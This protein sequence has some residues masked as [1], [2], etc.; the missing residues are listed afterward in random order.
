M[1]QSLCI[2]YVWLHFS[3][4]Q[5]SIAE[6]SLSPLSL[7]FEVENSS[8]RL[9]FFLALLPTIAIVSSIEFQASFEGPWNALLLC[10][11]R[12]IREILFALNSSSR[13]RTLFFVCGAAALVRCRASFNV[14]LFDM[15]IPSSLTLSFFFPHR[16][17][18]WPLKGNSH[19][20][21]FYSV[22]LDSHNEVSFEVSFGGG[23]RM[24]GKCD[25]G[26]RKETRMKQA[27]GQK[28]S[29]I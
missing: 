13:S 6:Q 29:R 25:F 21:H 2:N 14:P 10:K 17:L 9:L 16:W 27:Y 24:E 20:P 4:L 11:R 22:L 23:G 26:K 8:S 1:A 5:F 19:H 18:V 12:S 3:Q 15:K 28:I 7:I